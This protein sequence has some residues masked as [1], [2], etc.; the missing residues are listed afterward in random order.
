[1]LFLCFVLFSFFFHIIIILVII[2]QADTRKKSKP[3]W[4]RFRSSTINIPNISAVASTRE[5]VSNW[6]VAEVVTWLETMQ[7]GEY[8]ETFTRNDVRGKEL[9]TLTRRD[10]KELG[11]VKVGHVKRILQACKDLNST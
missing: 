1:M 10:L 6:G 5:T 11:I 4:M 9:L 2:K 7:L 3:F 8:V